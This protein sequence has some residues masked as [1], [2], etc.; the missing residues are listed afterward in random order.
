MFKFRTKV[1][2]GVGGSGWE[3]QLWAIISLT[4]L[5]R[6]RENTKHASCLAPDTSFCKS[7]C[8]PFMSL[9]FPITFAEVKERGIENVKTC[10]A[11][12]LLWLNLIILSLFDW[13]EFLS[14][15]KEGHEPHTSVC[16]PHCQGSPSALLL[17][18][19]L[20]ISQTFHPP[21]CPHP[22]PSWP[23]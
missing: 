20:P 13:A 12:F 21:L 19:H 1:C 6:N 5:H 14:N 18:L 4:A 22:T 7:L 3:R 2:D 23:R 16:A 17:I 15:S 9:E 11:K 8:S 10:L